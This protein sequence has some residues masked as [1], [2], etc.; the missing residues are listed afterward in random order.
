M[1]LPGWLEPLPD[2]EA[3]R[4]TD[5]WATEERGIPSLELME[6]AG[7]GLARAVRELAGDGPV[8]VVCGTGN[9]GGD[10]LVAARHLAG[11]G[12]E[13]RV[14]LVAEPEGLR[15]DAAANLERL[16]LPALPFRAD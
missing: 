16:G 2:A 12:R 6:R 11:E 14:L 1:T 15:G 10:G 5:R 7:A 4:A 3:M 8:V 9:N 13:L